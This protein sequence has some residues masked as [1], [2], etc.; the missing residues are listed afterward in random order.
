M[1]TPGGGTALLMGGSCVSWAGSAPPGADQ[2]PYRA[3]LMVLLAG[4]GVRVTAFP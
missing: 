1:L 4:G 3:P 2:K